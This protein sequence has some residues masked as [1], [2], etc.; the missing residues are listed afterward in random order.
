[1]S[2]GTTISFLGKFIPSD[3]VVWPGVT[4]VFAS[5]AQQAFAYL[6]DADCSF[7]SGFEKGTALCL[8]PGELLE[9]IPPSFVNLCRNV[10]EYDEEIQILGTVC[11]GEFDSVLLYD[12]PWDFSTIKSFHQNRF[13]LFILSTQLKNVPEWLPDMVDIAIT[14]TDDLSDGL[15]DRFFPWVRSQPEANYISEVMKSDDSIKSIALVAVP[16][17][18]STAIG[19]HLFV[20]RFSPL[21]GVIAK[22]PKKPPM[23]ELVQFN[24]ERL[25]VTNLR[26]PRIMILGNGQ[27]LQEYKK[28]MFHWLAERHDIVLAR[29][30]GSPDGYDWSNIREFIKRAGNV[31]ESDSIPSSLIA[32]PFFDRKQFDNE[33]VKTLFFEGR[34]LHISSLITV[35]YVNMIPR[36]AV[37]Q[38]WFT[39]IDPSSYDE[40]DGIRKDIWQKF[41]PS[42]KDQSDFDAMW[43]KHAKAGHVL[44]SDRSH[45]GPGIADHV[46][47]D[48][49]VQ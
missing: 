11:N 26:Y 44:I 27:R 7:R 20:E 48:E 47:W 32:L 43:D 2:T 4:L 14:L 5:S 22:S 8:A 37:S 9:V 45:N 10:E 41:F 33:I 29:N 12:C 34:F 13:P 23:P 15:M 31:G 36:W 6:G 24:L 1:M 46:F 38:I 21:P 3:H 28:K 19:S 42:I 16:H 30:R 17:G 18:F 49:C 35:T 25:L 40:F 39:I